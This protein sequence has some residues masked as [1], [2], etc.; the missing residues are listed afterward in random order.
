MAALP[1][2]LTSSGGALDPP[3]EAPYPFFFHCAA[4]RLCSSSSAKSVIPLLRKQFPNSKT[5]LAAAMDE[6]LRQFITK[7]DPIVTVYARVFP[8]LD[9][10]AI[11]FDGGKIEPRVPVLPQPVGETRSA[12]EAALVTMSGRHIRLQAAP[13]NLQLEARDVVFHQGRDAD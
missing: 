4:S 6:G 1:P 3:S 8:Y 12:V 2:S 11:N 9:G 5:E 10:I 13:I 7:S